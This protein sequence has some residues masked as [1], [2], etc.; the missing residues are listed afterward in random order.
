[1][2]TITTTAKPE[3]ESPTPPYYTPA[4][5]LPKL[6]M[7]LLGLALI[8]FALTQLGTPLNLLCRGTPT[9]AEATR[10]IKSKEGLPDVILAD[11]V[12]IRSAQEIR[13]RSYLFSNEFRFRTTQ[14]RDMVVMLPTREQLKPLFPLVDE[15]GMPTTVRI[16]YDPQKPDHVLFPLVFST[17]FIPGM[18]VFLG[19]VCTTI[20][21]TLLYWANKP[22]A[23]PHLPTGDALTGE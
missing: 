5:A 4:Y 23:L 15:D 8:G 7:T 18:I 3:A 17:W 6:L 9:M 2:N 19:M 22:I 16:Y 21:G 20:G 13:D 14:G 1:M 11:D 12:Q 10:V